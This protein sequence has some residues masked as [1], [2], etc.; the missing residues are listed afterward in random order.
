[1]PGAAF[2]RVELRLKKGESPVYGEE[3]PWLSGEIDR[4]RKEKAVVFHEVG[5]QK[6]EETRDAQW[7]RRK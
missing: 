5:P 3:E 7:K 2:S 1:M 6:E 4:L